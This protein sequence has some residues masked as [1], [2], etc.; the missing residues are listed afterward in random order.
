[1]KYN[2]PYTIIILF[3]QLFINFSS[4]LCTNEY[5]NTEKTIIP[6]NI[7]QTWEE[8]PL[9]NEIQYIVDKLK[10]ENPEFHHYLYDNNMRREFI[11]NNFNNI[12]VKTYD[13]LLP[14]AFKADLWRYCVLYIYGGIYIDIKMETV[15]NFK[16][17]EWTNKEYFIGSSDIVKNETNRNGIWNGIIVSKRKNSKLWNSIIKIVNHTKYESYGDFPDNKLVGS[18]FVTGPGLLGSFFSDDEIINLEYKFNWE[19]NTR[20]LHESIRYVYEIKSNKI[21]FIYNVSVYK[22]TKNDKKIIDYN[23]AFNNRNIYDKI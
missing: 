1:M 3:I 2:I 17:F 15:N 20:N 23:D 19:K 9:P 7:F 5:D 13:K 10:N 16:L 14:G 4:H 8:I 21:I 11:K 12:I 22:K 18:L 6:L